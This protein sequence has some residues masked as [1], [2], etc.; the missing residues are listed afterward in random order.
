[1]LEQSYFESTFSRIIS[2]S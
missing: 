1:M 2:H